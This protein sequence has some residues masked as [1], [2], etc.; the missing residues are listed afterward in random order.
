[1]FSQVTSQQVV[2]MSN[3]QHASVESLLQ[4][5]FSREGKMRGYFTDQNIQ[6]FEELS[7]SARQN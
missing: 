3:C 5:L 4:R 1:M 2:E 6:S 7:S